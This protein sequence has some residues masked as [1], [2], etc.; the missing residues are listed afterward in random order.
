[1]EDNSK[2]C[3]EINNITWTEMQKTM[4]INC[5][6]YANQEQT[7]N[8]ENDTI[9]KEDIE[10]EI[11][12]ISHKI[13]NIWSDDATVIRKL[14][15][16]YKEWTDFNKYYNFRYK[17]IAPKDF[18]GIYVLFWMEGE[19]MMTDKEFCEFVAQNLEDYILTQESVGVMAEYLDDVIREWSDGLKS[20]DRRIEKLINQW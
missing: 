16:I 17:V 15:K 6:H 18:E 13:A 2:Q 12:K 8:Y 4:C 5:I 14:C 7:C 1:M 19:H 3:I 9:C 10:K 11:K 20:I